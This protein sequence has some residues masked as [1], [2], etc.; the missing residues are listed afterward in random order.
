[1]IREPRLLSRLLPFALA[2]GLLGAGV[3]PLAF[4]PKAVAAQEQS[5]LIVD[6]AQTANPDLVQV[7]VADPNGFGVSGRTLM[8]PPGTTISIVAAQLGAPRFMTFDRAGNLYVTDFGRFQVLEFDRDGHYKAAFGSPGDGDGLCATTGHLGGYL[9]F[10]MP[11]LPTRAKDA[12][13][14]VLRLDMTLTA[15]ISFD[16]YASAGDAKPVRV[17][18]FGDPT[19]GSWLFDIRITP[20]SGV[21]HLDIHILGAEGERTTCFHQ[22]TVGTATT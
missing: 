15:P 22:V 9:R 18:E 1:M 4:G 3:A 21:T 2:G 5:A 13:P 11:R 8:A 10:D 6:D 12:G 7:E 19:K 17:S 20:E 14:L 16:V